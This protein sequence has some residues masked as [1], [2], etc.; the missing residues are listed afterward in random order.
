MLHHGQAGTVRIHLTPGLLFLVETLF[1]FYLSDFKIR[2]FLV[3][4]ALKQ[5]VNFQRPNSNLL[6]Q[7]F[8]LS[9]LFIAK[10][11]AQMMAYKTLK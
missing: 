9:V 11:S 6:Q 7:R 2:I 3:K 1:Y 10:Y 8:S 5:N 4:L